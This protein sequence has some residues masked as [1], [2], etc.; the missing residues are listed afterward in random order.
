MA[1]YVKR[2]M[3]ACGTLVYLGIR[4]N[5]H[6]RGTQRS[7]GYERTLRQKTRKNTP[8]HTDMYITHIQT[9]IHRQ[10]REDLG[11]QSSTHRKIHKHTHIYE[12]LKPW[13]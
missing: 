3:D 8:T 6:M 1:I 10:T 5:T 9:H 13:A 2:V 7:D 4:Q 11:T 12:D